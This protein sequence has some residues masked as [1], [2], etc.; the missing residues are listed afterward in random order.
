MLKY[1]S[2]LLLPRKKKI[3]IIVT[4]F[5]MCE[6][7]QTGKAQERDSISLYIFSY[8]FDL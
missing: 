4:G 6:S 1:L 8:L 7:G 5:F 3:L 2:P